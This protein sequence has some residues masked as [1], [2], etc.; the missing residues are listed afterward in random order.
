LSRSQARHALA[1]RDR[2]GVLKHQ[3]VAALGFGALGWALAFVPF[4]APLLVVG[5]TRMF[6]SL[7]AHDRV[8]SAL[9]DA[10]KLRLRA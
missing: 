6:L 1:A 3:T 8:P 2:L 4:T 9:T 10:E 5:G 7:A